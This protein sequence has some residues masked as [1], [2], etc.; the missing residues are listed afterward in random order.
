MSVA[1]LFPAHAKTLGAG[2]PSKPAVA[3]MHDRASG[4]YSESAWGDLVRQIPSGYPA[5]VGEG[6][7]VDDVISAVNIQCFTGDK[8][9]GIVSK[10]RGGRADIV[11]RDEAT[12]WR[13][14]LCLLQQGKVGLYVVSTDE[15]L[16][17]AR[18][19]LALLAGRT[20]ERI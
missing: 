9:C 18:H 8:P 19:T 1:E 10:E 13:L 6:A 15:E 14:G 4:R 5:G 20:L 3:A 12:R 17:I 16:M 2:K 11:D 7:L